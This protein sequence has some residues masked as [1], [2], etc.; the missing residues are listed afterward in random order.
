M[1][2]TG[3]CGTCH[4]LAVAG[5]HGSIGPNLDKV[6][7]TYACVLKQVTNGGAVKAPCPAI[8]GAIMPSFAHT[9]SPAQIQSVAKFVSTEAGKGGSSSS[10]STGGGL[11]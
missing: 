5:T 3:T 8:A 11:P 6:K 9:L 10:S 1:V 4:T 2:F 7:P